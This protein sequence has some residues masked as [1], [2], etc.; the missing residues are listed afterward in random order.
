MGDNAIHR[1][2]EIH[3]EIFLEKQKRQYSADL[4]HESF[5]GQVWKCPLHVLLKWGIYLHISDLF[6]WLLFS[7]QQNALCNKK[8][9]TEVR[10]KGPNSLCSVSHTA[11]S[12]TYTT[13]LTFFCCICP[14][15]DWL[16]L[17]WQFASYQMF[18]HGFCP[19]P[20][21]ED[22]QT[23]WCSKYILDHF[24]LCSQAYP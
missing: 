15:L 24:S 17:L 1:T 12:D 21:G 9:T 2:S 10:C 8:Q 6:C 16:N 13:I 11:C 7:E 19:I 5:Q 23:I 14:S 18:H 22:Q 3:S 20:L 4:N